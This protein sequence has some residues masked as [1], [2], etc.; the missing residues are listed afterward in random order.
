MSSCVHTDK[1]KKQIFK[2]LIFGE[3]PMEGLNGLTLTVEKEYW[4]NCT[5][6]TKK[7]V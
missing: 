1:K 4:I 7:F 6:T 2:F 3:G 5:T